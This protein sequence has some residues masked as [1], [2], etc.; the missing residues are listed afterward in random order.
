MRVLLVEDSVDVAE[1]I[2]AHLVRLGHT[3]DLESDGTK[4][5]A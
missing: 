4:A 2:N 3:V 1:A 5:A